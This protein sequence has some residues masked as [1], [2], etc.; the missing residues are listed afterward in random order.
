[1][2]QGVDEHRVD[3]GLGRVAAQPALRDVELLG[4]Q[5][6]GPVQGAQLTTSLVE[7]R[8]HAPTR[9]ITDHEIETAAPRMASE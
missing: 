1:M 8:H 7:K 5:P 6:R 9:A 4:Q 2:G 3:E